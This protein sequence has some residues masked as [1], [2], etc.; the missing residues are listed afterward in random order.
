[1]I[2]LNDFADAVLSSVLKNHQDTWQQVKQYFIPESFGSL[3][4]CEIAKAIM[5][6]SER[7]SFSVPQVVA[8]LNGNH[9]LLIM[10]LFMSPSAELNTNWMAK[11]IYDWYIASQSA[12]VLANEIAKLM[13][14]NVNE[15]AMPIM[16][17]IKEIVEQA[18]SGIGLSS[19]HKTMQETLDLWTKRLEKRLGGEKPMSI[20]TTIPKLDD[21]IGGM[22]G[23]RF[24]I[25]AARPSVGKTSFAAFLAYQAMKQGKHV[26]FF[27]NE[28]DAEDIAEKFLAMDARITNTALNG[29]MTDTELTRLSE[30]MNRLH[31]YN[32]SIDE[33]SGWNLDSLIAAAH[34]HKAR[35]FCDM[36]VVDYMQQVKTNSQASKYEQASKVSD[37]LKKLSRDLNIPVVGLAQIN[38]EAERADQSPSLVHIKDSGSFEQDADVVFILHRDKLAC[39]ETYTPID[40]RVAKNRYGKVGDIKLKFFHAFSFY[41]EL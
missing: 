29:A 3:E 1:M 14:G 18:E 16:A 17:R 4:R 19:Q 23:G 40:L 22:K 33:K 35:R 25:V 20:V 24:Y 11:Q 8:E 7:G 26:L 34:S 10:N 6:V 15:S 41:Q 36:V 9:K 30:S 13:T 12:G 2:G 31:T 38:R 27:S 5:T 21:S 37:A 39:A 28:M 32:I